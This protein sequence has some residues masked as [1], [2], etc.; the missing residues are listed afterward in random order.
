MSLR[1]L[2]ESTGLSR[3]RVRS[4]LVDA[5]EQ[6][7]SGRPDSRLPT[8]PAWWV[9]RF[10]D[11]RSVS[12]LANQ[13]STNIVRIYRH[14]RMLDVPPPSAQTLERWLAARTVREGR[15]R[16]WLGPVVN[17]LPMA[18]FR[19]GDTRSVRRIVWEDAVGRTPSRTWIVRA[20]DCPTTACV[21][22]SH[23]RA[24]DPRA[25]IIERVEA[26]RFRWG[27]NHGSAKLTVA[28]ARDILG[29]RTT[30]AQELALRYHVSSSTV[31][32][33]WSGRRWRHLQDRPAVD[34]M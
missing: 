25:H 11:G 31:Q 14:L 7:R 22:I 9:S 30:P 33:I 13:L 8:D 16:R 34:P 17:G 2:S 20:S 12:E 21:E 6:I 19:T 26:Q 24:V 1:A 10:D 5:G 29:D 23:L 15:C 32:A 18:S 27:E 3:K 28:Q 4:L